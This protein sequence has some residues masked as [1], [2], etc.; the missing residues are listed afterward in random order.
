[1]NLV[2]RQTQLG[3]SLF[4]INTQ[5]LAETAE[6]ARKNAEQYFETNRTFGERLP[7]VREVSSL[8]SLQR[9]YGQTLWNNAKAAF[10]AQGAILQAAMGGTREA[11]ETAFTTEE[12]KPKAKKPQKAKTQKAQ[13]A[14]A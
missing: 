9:E 3:K 6:L 2:D 13:G 14:A 7:E 12:A 1:M 10:Q 11:L 4:E 5:V 8:F